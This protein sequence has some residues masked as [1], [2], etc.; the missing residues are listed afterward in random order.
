MDWLGRRTRSRP[1]PWNQWNV[2]HGHEKAQQD[3]E[4]TV[5][6]MESTYDYKDMDLNGDVIDVGVMVK[7]DLARIEGHDIV[8]VDGRPALGTMTHSLAE[9]PEEMANFRVAAPM[10][11][12]PAMMS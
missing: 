9:G 11:L 10:G 5:G 12:G 6:G 7:E 1:A 4:N 3:L 2:G 8:S